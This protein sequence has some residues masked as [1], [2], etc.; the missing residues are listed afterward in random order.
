MSDTVFPVEYEKTK[1]VTV[2]DAPYGIRNDVEY[3][4]YP[5]IDAVEV[6]I[7]IRV[8]EDGSS[9]LVE[10]KEREQIHAESIDDINWVPK[11]ELDK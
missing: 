11:E 9:E 3:S 2:E 4:P 7:T 5:L 8:Y 6:V 1:V 10:A